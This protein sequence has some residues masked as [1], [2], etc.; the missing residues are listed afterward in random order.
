MTNSRCTGTS[1]RKGSVHYLS[2]NEGTKRLRSFL[3]GGGGSLEV[4]ET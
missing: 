2:F 3:G 1:V 4:Q